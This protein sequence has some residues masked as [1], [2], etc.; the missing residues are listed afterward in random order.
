MSALPARVLLSGCPGVRCSR[1]QGR[2]ELFVNVPRAILGTRL[3]VRRTA[4]FTVLL[5]RT[6]LSLFISRLFKYHE[7]NIGSEDFW[8][9][10]FRCKSKSA[11]IWQYVDRSG[12]G[13]FF[14]AV[15]LACVVAYWLD[16]LTEAALG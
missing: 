15:Q 11:G 3:V 8:G 9:D 4:T 7:T 16:R 12:H 6:T 5:L 1:V 13:Y 14:L 10:I 2:A